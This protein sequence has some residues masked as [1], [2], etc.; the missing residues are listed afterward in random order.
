LT[1]SIIR[2]QGHAVNDVDPTIHAMSRRIELHVLAGFQLLDL[3]GPL[4]VFE[5][6]EEVAPGSYRTAVISQGGGSVTSSSGL[7]VTTASPHESRDTLIIVGGYT[8]DAATASQATVD[9]V[10]LLASRSRRTAS[11]CTGAILLAATGL[12]DGRRATTHWQQF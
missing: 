2:E 3:T 1:G 12:L 10:R 5:F 11:V 6:A 4:T 7:K 8:V 9:A